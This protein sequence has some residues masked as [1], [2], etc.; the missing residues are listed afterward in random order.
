MSVKS[1]EMLGISSMSVKS[2]DMLGKIEIAKTKKE[3]GKR[4]LINTPFRAGNVAL[5]EGDLQ[6]AMRMYHESLLYITGL[7]NSQLKA[8]VGGV[9]VPLDS[10]SKDEIKAIS[11]SS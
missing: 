11:V 7:D 4:P 3:S 9:S 8:I 10:S 6:K 2:K 1:K 5:K